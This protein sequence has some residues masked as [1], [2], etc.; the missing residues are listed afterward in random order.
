MVPHAQAFD[1][2]VAPALYFI[3]GLESTIGNTKVSQNDPDVHFVHIWVPGQ[4]L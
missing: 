2:Y 1:N 4:V 3:I